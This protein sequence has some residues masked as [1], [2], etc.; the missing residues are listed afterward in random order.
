MITLLPALAILVWL[1]RPRAFVEPVRVLA[2]V[3]IVACCA[4]Q[5]GLLL[6]RGADGAAPYRAEPIN[7]PGDLLPFVTGAQF[8]RSMFAFGARELFAER[9]PN[10]VETTLQELAPLALLIP[11][12]VLALGRTPANAFLLLAWLGNLGFALAYDISDVRAY[13]IPNHVIGALYLGVG[14]DRLLQGLAAGAAPLARA[15]GVIAVSAPLALGALRVPRVIAASGRDAASQAQAI[16]AG[17]PPG[18]ILIAGYETRQFL[19]YYRLIEK[20]APA[21]PAIADESV[22]LGEVLAYLRDRKPLRIR[23]LGL[24]VPPGLELY[25]EK[26]FAPRRY[27]RAGLQ[28]EPWRLDL[29]RITYPGAAGQ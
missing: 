10:F 29:Y 6:V 17:V 15:V 23:Q 8:Q 16:L 22:E 12:G 13:F 1:T 18:A 24:V 4:A 7:G 2:V 27:E 19:L 3:A 26:L 20:R 9:L 25:S 14:L 28:V 11:V 5:Y 21:G